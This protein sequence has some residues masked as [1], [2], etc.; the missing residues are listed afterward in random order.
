MSPDC[1]LSIISLVHSSKLPP[2]LTDLSTRLRLLIRITRNPNI[3][4]RASI[5]QHTTFA[6]IPLWAL[7]CPT[8]NFSSLLAVLLP[9]NPTASYGPALKV[10]VSIVSPIEIL[11]STVPMVS[12]RIKMYPLI[13]VISKALFSASPVWM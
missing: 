12:G 2:I 4:Q 10:L 13:S 8:L 3:L 1:A 6:I 9:N 7:K 11:I 5:L